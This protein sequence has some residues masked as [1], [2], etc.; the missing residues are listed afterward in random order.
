M[1][2]DVYLYRYENF[3]ETRERE[4]KYNNLSDDL[5]NKKNDEYGSY[6]AIPDEAKNNIRE[7]LDKTLEVMGLGKWGE[8]ENN[9][10]KIEIN[11]KLYPDH[12]FKVGYFRSS[13]NSGGINNILGNLG[14]P[15]LY[16]IFSV[17]EEDYYIQPHWE[18]CLVRTNKAIE[19]L[20]KSG[21]YR[22]HKF[23]SNPFG[24][25]A[26]LPRTEAEALDI[27]RS[28]IERDGKSPEYNYSNNKGEFFINEPIKIS[29][30]IPGI[31]IFL[32]KERECVYA[33]TQPKDENN[34]YLEALEIVKETIE[35]VLEQD[36]IEQY[37]LH[38]SG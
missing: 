26:G 5:W 36:K 31:E 34:W 35:Y 7:T 23:S 20:K 27:F 4:T 17:N 30:I 1:G 12:Y 19:A 32:G 13:Y 25:T 14:L 3:R 21:G 6:D 38:W 18:D 33:I 15:D 28:Q 8:D 16:D 10:E 24:G 2:L 37:Y 29:A 11:S 9:K 22:I